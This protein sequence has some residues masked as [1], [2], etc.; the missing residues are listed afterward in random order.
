MK[1]GPY[2][3]SWSIMQ[4]VVKIYPYC[5]P[6]C[7]MKYRAS[8]MGLH[9]S[10]L[11]SQNY[12]LGDEILIHLQLHS[13]TISLI[14]SCHLSQVG[15]LSVLAWVGVLSSDTVLSHISYVYVCLLF[16]VLDA[17]I[18]VHLLLILSLTSLN[19]RTVSTQTK[20]GAPSGIP[21]GLRPIQALVLGCIDGFW[22]GGTAGLCS[23]PW[24]S[25]LQYCVS[26]VKPCVMENVKRTTQMATSTFFP[27]IRQSSRSLTVHRKIP[28]ESGTAINPCWKLQNVT[29]SIWYGCQDIRELMEM[30]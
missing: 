24:Y 8:L 9:Y 20:K 2:M 26:A 13:H 22:A 21:M 7:H 10:Y 3:T 16:D 11:I 25:R 23:T 14:L 28:N 30:K 4:P 19:G 6:E 12:V 18:R 29:G 15:V 27:T 17:D 1:L 5:S